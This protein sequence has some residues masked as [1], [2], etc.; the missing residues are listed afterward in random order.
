M[1]MHL[2][3]KRG[4]LALG[5]FDLLLHAIRYFFDFSIPASAKGR[6]SRGGWMDLN[7]VLAIMSSL[8]VSFSK[9]SSG[10]SLR[11]RAQ[12]KSV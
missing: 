2:E 6:T 7:L 12:Q 10:L 5:D 8:G 9:T 1:H 4:S 11:Q 3:P